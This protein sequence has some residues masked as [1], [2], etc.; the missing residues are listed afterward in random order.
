VLTS[1]ARVE[2]SVLR[3]VGRLPFGLSILALARA[4]A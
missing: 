3:R 4:A 2:R 1:A